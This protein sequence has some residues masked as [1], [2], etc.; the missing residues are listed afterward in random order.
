MDCRGVLSISALLAFASCADRPGQ[1]DAARAA[2]IESTEAATS[3]SVGAVASAEAAPSFEMTRAM[4][5]MRDGVSL[6]TVILAPRTAPKDLPMLLVRTP[7]GVPVDE[8]RLMGE[9]YAPL[10]ADGYVFVWQSVRGLFGSEGTFVAERP[11]RSDPSDPKAVDETTDAYDTIEWLVQHVPKHNGRVGMFG[12]SYMAWTAT[13][14]LLE[15]HPAL[16]VISE[17]ASPADQFLGDDLHHNGAFRLSYA[18]EF[19]AFLESNKARNTPFEFDRGDTYDWFLSLGP[20][21]RVNERHFHGRFSSWNELVEHP[22]RDDFWQRRSLGPHLAKLPSPPVPTLNVAGFW[23]QEDFFGPLKIY[24]SLERGDA[25]GVNHLIIGPWNHDGWSGSGRTLGDIDFGSDTGV[26]YREQLQAPWLARWLHDKVGAPLP[27]ARVFVTGKNEWQ[28]FERWPPIDGVRPTRLYLRAGWKLG[29]EPPSEN[30]GGAFD[31]YV[32]DPD[33]PVP[34]VRR[35]IRPTFEDSD[36]PLWQV[37]DQRFVG[38]R[39]DAPSWETDALDRDVVVLGEVVAEL[40]ASTSGTDSDWIVK[41]IDVYPEGKRPA[42]P[43]SGRSE[44]HSNEAALP[45]LRG[46]QLMIAGEVMRGRFHRSFERPEKLVPDRMV[47]YEVPLS[48]RAHVFLKG[49]KI[50]VQIQSTWFPLIDRNPQ[51]FMPSIFEARP[52]HFVKARQ[53]IGRSRGAASA[54]VLPVLS[55]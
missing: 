17:A 50:R 49:H 23:D 1:R 11:P 42:V 26:Y 52:E 46:Y 37:L 5:P 55:P 3:A 15:P 16:K 14:A 33:N 30:E 38:H 53:R 28:S 34:Y 22:N 21:S 25:R 9:W 48:S 44:G 24:E 36:W 8:R 6:E 32:S 43:R 29:F 41:L 4:V 31:E 12:G 10:R 13:M 20:L 18:F 7:Y 47:R 35:P 39:P 51:T 40:F 27:G 45:D 2:P 54:I 19:S